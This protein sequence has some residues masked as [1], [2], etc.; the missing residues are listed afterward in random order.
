MRRDTAKLLGLLGLPLIL[1]GLFYLTGLSETMAT[2]YLPAWQ[3]WSDGHHGWASVLL[4]FIFALT[5][6][7]GIPRIYPA[8][9]MGGFFSIPL[10][11]VVAVT[12][13]TAGSMLP[14]AAARRV[15]PP[16][17]QRKFG[18]RYRAWVD[19]INASGFSV[20]LLLRLFPGSNAMLVNM[21]CGISRIDPLKFL[22]ATGIGILPSTIAFVLLGG[23]LTRNDPQYL[24]VS[25]ITLLVLVAASWLTWRNMRRREAGAPGGDQGDDWLLTPAEDRLVE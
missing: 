20:V 1:I 8:I 2:D 3:A 6:A 17:V 22:A 10:A 11:V 21:V 7:A 12:G 14:F 25:V 13:A 23:G 5:T 9:L 18:R 24:A 16:V 15:G 4:F 19:R